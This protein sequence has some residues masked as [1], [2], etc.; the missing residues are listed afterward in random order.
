[1]HPKDLGE[2]KLNQLNWTYEKLNELD[3]K[4]EKTK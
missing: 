3:Y 1:M 2:W 4:R